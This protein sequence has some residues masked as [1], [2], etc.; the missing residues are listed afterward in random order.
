LDMAQAFDLMRGYAR[1]RRR[2][3]ADVARD[4]LAGALGLGDLRGA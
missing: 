1:R 2:R 3:L 4:V